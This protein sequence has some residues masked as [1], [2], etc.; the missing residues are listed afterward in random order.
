M[1]AVVARVSSA[2]CRIPRETAFRDRRDVAHLAACVA[3]AG[4]TGGGKRRLTKQQHWKTFYAGQRADAIG[5][6]EWWQ[7]DWTRGLDETKQ[8][9]AVTLEQVSDAFDEYIGHAKPVRLYIL[10]EK[11]PLWVSLFGWLY[12]LVSR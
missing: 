5:R 7:S 11:V 2:G 4:D 3:D 8:V 9:E 12:P 1:L 10:P 6:A